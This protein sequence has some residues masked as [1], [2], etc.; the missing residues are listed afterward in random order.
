MSDIN[1]KTGTSTES[2]LPENLEFLSDQS[3]LMQEY[4][5]SLYFPD[6]TRLFREKCSIHK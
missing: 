6:W 5:L 4:L 3:A 2:R 1:S